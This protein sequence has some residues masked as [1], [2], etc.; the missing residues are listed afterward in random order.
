[1][2]L[3]GFVLGRLEAEQIFVT[4]LSGCCILQLLR[5]WHAMQRPLGIPLSDSWIVMPHQPSRESQI[6]SLMYPAV[7]QLLFLLVRLEQKLLS[8]LL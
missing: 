2:S 7:F 1:M 5:Q 8:C 3:R 4:I 6:A